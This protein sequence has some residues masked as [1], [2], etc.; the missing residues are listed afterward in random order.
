[1]GLGFTN[2]SGQIWEEGKERVD[3]FLWMPLWKVLAALVVC[4]WALSVGCDA[5]LTF[6]TGL[7]DGDP[8]RLVTVYISGRL[9]FAIFSYVYAC[10]ADFLFLSFGV[11]KYFSWMSQRTRR[12]ISRVGI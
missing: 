4:S 11:A 7:M 2:D 1:M 6:G 9:S 12:V 5:T 10:C 3:I 8:D